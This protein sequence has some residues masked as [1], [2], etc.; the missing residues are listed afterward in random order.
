V[1]D[2]W[3]GVGTKLHHSVGLWPLLVDDT[4][5]VTE[6][7]PGVSLSLRTR[8][9]PA[10]EA[11][12]HLHLGPHGPDTEVRMEEDAVSG[13]GRLVPAPARGLTLKWRNTESLRRLAYLA[14]RRQ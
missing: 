7:N 2:G 13:P 3:P 1:D 10:G 6:V 11:A 8:A 4:T 9:W 5:E 14:E 12:V